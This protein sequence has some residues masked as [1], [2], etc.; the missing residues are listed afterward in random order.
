MLYFIPFGS[1]TSSGL[2]ALKVV[3]DVRGR[4]FATR[5]MIP[6]SMMPLAFVLSGV[7]AD[8]VFNPLMV[9]GGALA[10]TFVGRWIG[11]GPGR[12]IGLIL[13]SSGIFLLLVSGI[14]FANRYI[15]RIEMEIPDVVAQPEEE[16]DVVVPTQLSQEAES[17]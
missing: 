12:G 9:E 3:P 10:D 17:A 8:K 2:F 4:V 14:A 1:S 15:R 16:Q 7:L 13:I 6:R 11:V 5:S